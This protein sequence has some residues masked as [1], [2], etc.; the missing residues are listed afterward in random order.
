MLKNWKL[1]TNKSNPIG[2][3]LLFIAVQGITGRMAIAQRS[4]PT[5]PSSLIAQNSPGKTQSPPVLCSAQLGDAIDSVINRPQFQRFRWGILVEPIFGTG[6]LYARDRDR[7]FI[8]ASNAK[9]FTTA[10]ALSKLSPNYRIRTSV[11]NASSDPNIKSLRFVGRGDPSLTDDQLKALAQQLKRQG[12]DQIQQLVVDD[13]YFQGTQINP[14][15][16]WEDVQYY[17]GTTVNSL[18]LNQNAIGLTI[19]PQKPGLP[20]KVS[21]NDP[22]SAIS[23]QVE[24]NSVTSAPG[25][26]S[27]V[28]FN[29]FLG[30]PV[31]RIS[32]QLAADAQ[33]NLQ[34]LAVIDP[35]ETFSRHLRV[36]LAGQQIKVANTQ[37]VSTNNIDN[38]QELAAVES[39]PLGALVVETNQN[40]NNLYAEA[41]LRLLG[42]TN[43]ELAT[44]NQDTAE[45]GLA[46]VKQTLTNLGVDP[47][48]YKLVDGSGLSRHNLVSPNAIV[49]TLKAMAKSPYAEYYRGSLP[50]AG[51]SGTL[52]NRLRDTP[53]QGILLAKTGTMTGVVALSGYLNAPIDQPV[54]FSILV[55]Q[56]DQSASVMRQ[57]MDEIV[58]LLTRVR[59]C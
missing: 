59:T 51:F 54:V 35:G 2:V 14:S 56:S 39:A 32:G 26:E 43:K 50:I 24:N 13:G 31:L 36:A 7:Y 49:Q 42:A 29:S 57:A 38:T 6:T 3:L 30:K 48:S 23:W 11:Y 10:A 15:W 25:S 58:L 45:I 44:N 4:S 27:S 21:W 20:L 5:L 12:Y 9:L 33:P 22:I 37:V 28:Q 46:T 47:E 17:Y 52:K 34:A 1:W 53:A 19:S 18:I 16:E 55:N 8:P 40:S 41:L